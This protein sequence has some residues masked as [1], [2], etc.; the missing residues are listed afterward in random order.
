M[1]HRIDSDAVKN[2]M[3]KHN[4]KQDRKSPVKGSAFSLG[5]KIHIGNKAHY[6]KQRNLHSKHKVHHLGIYYIGYSKILIGLNSSGLCQFYRLLFSKLLNK[7]IVR[8]NFA[9]FKFSYIVSYIKGS[10]KEILL[11]FNHS[12]M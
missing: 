4:Y 3:Y 11:L 1:M 12:N 7:L 8:D 10:F 5:R 9:N 6:K 2:K